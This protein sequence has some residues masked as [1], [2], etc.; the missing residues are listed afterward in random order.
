MTSDCNIATGQLGQMAGIMGQISSLI[1][2]AFSLV[3][4]GDACYLAR[5]YD[6]VHELCLG[7]ESSRRSSIKSITNCIVWVP[8]FSI[9]GST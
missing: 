8:V 5:V 2:Q 3:S 9:D 1:K 6:A 4:L 7:A